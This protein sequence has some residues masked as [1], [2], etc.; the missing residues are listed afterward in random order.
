MTEAIGKVPVKTQEQR[1]KE[2]LRL[3]DWVKKILPEDYDKFDVKAEYDSA[4]SYD[5]NKSAM[6]DKLKLLIK[7][8][9]SQAQQAVADQ[10]R[11]EQ[12]SIKEAEKEVEEYNRNLVY[13]DKKEI[14]Q[15]YQPIING[16][17]K[18]CQ[19][20]SN[21]LFIK[22]R[23]GIGKSY[24]IRKSL[25]QNKADFVEVAGEVTEAY[26]YRLIYENNGKIIWFKDVVK[27]LSGLGSINL[28]KSATETEDKKILTKNN[29]S[30]QQDDL[31]NTFVCKCKF[32]F[33]YNNIFGSQLK[34]DFEALA[35]RGDYKEVP[36]C[37]EDVKQIMR[38]VAKDEKE[39]EITEFII[40]QFEANNVVKLN[41][42][43]QWKAKRTKEYCESNNHDW[44]KVLSDELNNV[45][46]TRAMLYTLIGTKAVKTTELKK[47]IMKQELVSSLR[48]AHR[49][50]NEWLYTDELYKWS[51][52]ERD[53]YVCINQKK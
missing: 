3:R 6:R 4:I 51:S 19:G 16:I 43:T 35:T 13:D 48:T 45:S 53:F 42:R 31:P 49:K 52:V 32:I 41:L 36:F 28:L 22:G 9:K 34:E 44:K 15:F 26:L 50:I 5:E 37:D 23:G 27:L 8:V 17:N 38:L 33:D 12:E 46:K 20:Y 40:N 11:L 1:D 2:L 29:Y 30:K 21:L 24:Q 39:K 47:L 10:E 18:L 7:D 25:V 14:D